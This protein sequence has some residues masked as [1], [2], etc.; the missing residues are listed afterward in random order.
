M[1]EL[2]KYKRNKDEKELFLGFI[3]LKGAYD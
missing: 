3:D 1:E 2:N